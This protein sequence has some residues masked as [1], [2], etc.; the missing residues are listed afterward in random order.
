MKLT[1]LVDNHTSIDHYYLGEP[2]LCY[3]IEDEGSRFL[4]DTGY[5]D[6]YIEN[7]RRLGIDLSLI[8]TI[9]LSHGH[10]DHTG[11]LPAYFEHFDNPGLKI[12]AHP[13]ALS[14][15]Q[16][17]GENIGTTGRESGE[18]ES[19]FLFDDSALAHTTPDGIYIVTGCSHSGICN[20]VEYAKKVTGDSRVLGIIGGFH[21]FKLDGQVDRTIQ[22]FLDNHIE[23]LLPCHCTSFRVRA[24]IHQA[25]PLKRE[26]GVGLTIEW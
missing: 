23:R 14:E 24:Q 10:N 12:I 15:K 1:V 4:L 3:Y 6:I 11:G 8:D 9:V 25:I 21:L 16:F 18:G 26:V 22:Y 7:A 20:I 17:D 5:S 2:G 19:D 13:E